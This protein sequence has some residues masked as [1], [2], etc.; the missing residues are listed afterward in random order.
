M[1]LGDFNMPD[2]DWPNDTVKHSCKFKSLYDDFI[3]NLTHFNLEQMVKIPTREQNILD[4]LLT[5]HPSKV[6]ETKSLP[7]LSTSDHEIVFHE[8][9]LPIGRPIQPK[10]KIKI[11]RKANWEQFKTDLNL[12]YNNTFKH[13]DNSNPNIL[14]DSFKSELAKLSE[15]HIPTK[16]TKPRVD[17]PWLTNGIKRIIHKR[18]KLYAKIKKSKVNPKLE[19]M[20]KKFK[21]LK[22]SVQTKIRKSYWDY[23]ES[24][25]FTND[26]DNYKN[27]K[28]YTFVKHKKT[29]NSGI[30]PLK[31]DGITYT[32]PVQKA[33][34]LNNQFKSVFSKPKPLKLK[35]LSEINMFKNGKPPQNINQMPEIIISQDGVE[36]LLKGLNPNKA[37]GPDEL[38]PKL[39][40]ELHHDIAPILT[41]IFNSSL[42]S[43]IVPQD[44]RSAT[45]A[46]IYKKGPKCKPCNYRPISLTCIASKLIEHILVSNIMNRFDENNILSPFQHGFRS[47]HSCESQLIGFTQEIF[48]NLESGKQT[49]LIV[50]DFSKAFDKVDHNLLTYKLFKLGIDIKS[51]SWI[52]SF[53]KNR[54]QTVAVEGY[55]SLSVPVMSGVPQGSVLGPCLFLA[56]IND[57][58]DSLKSRVRLFAD[59][60]IVYLTINSK[61]DP[62][63]LQNDLLTLEKWEENWSMEFNADKC[64]VIRIS[65]KKNNIIYPY[66]LHNTELK[67]TNNAKYLGV[68]LSNDFKFSTHIDNVSSKANNTLKFIKRNVQTNNTKIK[69]TAYNTYVRPQLEYCSSIWHPWQQAQTYKIER[70]Q[71]AAARY[72]LNNYDFTSS[73]TEMLQFL[74]WQTLHQRRINT[75]LILLYKILNNLIA[76]DHHHLIPIK[77]LNFH[78]PFSRTLY[79]QNS[80]F[81]RT[82]RSWN[83]LPSHIKASTSLEQFQAGLA[84]VQF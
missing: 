4:L 22:K 43:G 73:V 63:T 41:C 74:N 8:I 68:T 12:Y 42:E 49:D 23:L 54:S 27:K 25:I 78:V 47:K 77:N 3:D 26:Q 7:S 84:T 36:T 2:M 65:K 6:H 81:P 64:E 33:N 71:R 24:I 37:S 34:I 82:I 38:S 76:V 53:L 11:Y 19:N 66:K 5:N 57:L 52:T 35:Y 50:M 10:R 30:S 40:K 58:P 56:Y 83:S 60:T 13:L 20:K 31:A 62:E 17:L 16:M 46:P 39:L 69:E 48:D 79:H 21:T 59:D 67:T 32:D 9:N 18:D 1:V 61:S 14:W 51:V 44:W 45:V 72:V 28:F 70:V 29:D 80:F 75:S 15:T 55:K